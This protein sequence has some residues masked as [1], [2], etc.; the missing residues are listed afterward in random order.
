MAPPPEEGGVPPR[1]QRRRGTA[2]AA[3]RDLKQLPTKGIVSTGQ[4]GNGPPKL[5]TSDAVMPFLSR[6]SIL[7][8][9]AVTDIALNAEEKH[10]V[11]AKDMAGRLRLSPRHLEPVLQALVREGILKGIRGPQGG[12]RLARQQ[13]QI[14][15]EDLLRIAR[16]VA[17]D[18]EE[19][20]PDL[21]LLKEVVA[22]AL[23]KA[24]RACSDSWA[25]ISLADLTRSAAT[26]RKPEA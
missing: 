26:R 10:A 24:Q 25:R 8:I 23:A 7:A 2:V 1:L 9:A 20:V 4:R 16:T 5:S 22:P 14:T 13:G 12:Y 17:P 6:K 15:A 3:L 11:A 19:P 18:A 21:P